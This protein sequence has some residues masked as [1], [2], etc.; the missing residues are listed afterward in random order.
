MPCN[1]IKS[2]PSKEELLNYKT[3]QTNL[4]TNTWNHEQSYL[5]Y[6][7]FLKWICPLIIFYAIAMVCLLIY[8]SFIDKQIEKDGGNNWNRVLNSALIIY[9]FIGTIFIWEISPNGETLYYSWYEKLYSMNYNA[10]FQTHDPLKTMM[11]ILESHQRYQQLVK[12]LENNLEL[13]RKYKFFE[14]FNNN[15]LNC[16]PFL[17]RK[18]ERSYQQN[19]NTLHNEQIDFIFD[20]FFIYLTS[21]WLLSIIWW[22]IVWVY[23]GFLANKP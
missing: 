14:C 6:R 21:I 8:S 19:L 3:E 13:L 18:L 2:N 9:L 12:L 10:G 23:K 17:D 1:I 11:N 22:L 15:G 20:A 5:V 7:T 4:L 16:D